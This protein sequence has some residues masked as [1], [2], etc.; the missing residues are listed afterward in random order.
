MQTQYTDDGLAFMG[1]YSAPAPG[2]SWGMASAPP[3][4]VNL[5]RPTSS[6]PRSSP[7]DAYWPQMTAP[8][9]SPYGHGNV[10]SGDITMPMYYGHQP[11]TLTPGSS[12]GTIS[13]IG[14]G[15][16]GSAAGQA[17]FASLAPP[18]M[19]GDALRAPSTGPARRRGQSDVT[20]PAEYERQRQKK[21]EYAKT[22]RDNEKHYFEQLRVRLF[23]TDPNT[24]RAEC[25]ER[26]VSAL[27]E[28]DA[29]KARAATRD[30][31]VEKLRAELAQAKHRA[32][33]LEQF[34][35]QSGTSQIPSQAAVG[36]Y[37]GYSSQSSWH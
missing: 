20:D 18:S 16:S 27:D 21:K 14:H 10:M 24:R 8:P 6:E 31:E 19:Q 36:T 37:Q 3:S 32:A 33:E 28:L 34:V 29:Y 12:S 2:T 22:F 9:E 15:R 13:D 11:R 5:G 1:S 30:A 4:P 25:L 23:P 26:A 17:S 35:A 7:I